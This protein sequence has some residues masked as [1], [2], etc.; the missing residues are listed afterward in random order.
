MAEISFIFKTKS[1]AALATTTR[2]I[3]KPK[4]RKYKERD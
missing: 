2:Y 3:N 1:G 4:Q